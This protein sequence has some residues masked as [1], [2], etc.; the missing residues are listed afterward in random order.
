MQDIFLMDKRGVGPDGKIMTETGPTGC[1]P[2]FLERLESE[3]I[4]LPPE[5]FAV[6]TGKR[7]GVW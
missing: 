7:K 1:R 4:T 2:L 3:G 5:M 6:A